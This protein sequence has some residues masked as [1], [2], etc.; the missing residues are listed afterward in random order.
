MYDSSLYISE[1]EQI[2]ARGSATKRS[3]EQQKKFSM[4]NSIAISMLS[5]FGC[6]IPLFN[7]FSH[8]MLIVS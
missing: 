1:N 5:A 7:E 2:V 6:V 3:K 4:K 8:L